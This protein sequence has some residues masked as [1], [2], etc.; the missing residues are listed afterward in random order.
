MRTIGLIGGL[1]WESSLEYY[2]V[3]NRAVRERLGGLHSAKCVMVSVDFAE[4]ESLQR[5][6]RWDEMAEHM[7][8][9]A[10]AAERGGA[11]LVLICSNTMHRVADEV[12][13]AVG[14]PLLHIVDAVAEQ[15]AAADIH[16]IGLLGTK[17]T[18]ESDLYRSRLSERHQ[19]SVLVPDAADAE[20][21]H[22][23]I[24]DELCVGVVTDKSRERLTAITERLVQAGSEG[25]VLGC[26]EL[27]LALTAGD[28]AVQLFD[29]TKIHGLAA[30]DA[31]L[32][33]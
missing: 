6:A 7:T 17:Y 3:I 25:V 20:E 5:R 4:V 26:T 11:D 23:I 29:S 14:I 9:A 13:S 2:R 32:A 19:I 12:E 31:A 8:V 16:R 28:T 24:Y 21:V 22:R 30:V 27:G 18:M 33:G 10:R 15:V 1:S